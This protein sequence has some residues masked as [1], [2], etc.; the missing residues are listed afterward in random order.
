MIGICMEW[1]RKSTKSKVRL[2]GVQAE[3]QTEYLPNANL[4]RYRYTNLPGL[5]SSSGLFY[6]WYLLCFN[7][8]FL[9][10]GWSRWYPRHSWVFLTETQI[11]A[12]HSLRSTFSR[13]QIRWLGLRQTLI[14]GQW[15][16]KGQPTQQCFE[17]IKQNRHY[18]QQSKSSK[19]YL[20]FSLSKQNFVCI[21]RL[22][23]MRY[24]PLPSHPP[25]IDYPT[26]DAIELHRFFSKSSFRKIA[27]G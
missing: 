14:M 2:A 12:E 7:W 13:Q 23:H 16:I 24:L 11:P 15:Y 6:T 1:L 4:Q 10:K 22:S 18:Y 9:L 5:L 17:T 19:S 25:W 8:I 20:P 27:T 26:W 21:S 3:I